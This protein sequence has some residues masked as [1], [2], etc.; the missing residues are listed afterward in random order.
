MTRAPG[1]LMFRA[2]TTALEFWIHV[3]PRARRESVG[4]THGDAL[5]VCVAAAPVHGAANEACARALAAAFEVKRRDVQIEAGSR[6]RR[7]RVQV[8]GD[9]DALGQRLVALAAAGGTQ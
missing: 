4:G 3:T 1:D 7:K 2:S 6:G 8:C 9:P 5:R